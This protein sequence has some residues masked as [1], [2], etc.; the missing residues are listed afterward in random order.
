MPSQVVSFFGLLMM[1]AIAWLMSYNRGSIRWRPVIWGVLL[2]F[3]IAAAIFHVPHVY[4]VFSYMGQGVAW[5]VEKVDVGAAFVFGE[6]Y[7]EHFFAFSVC[8]TIIF[9]SALTSLLYYLNIIPKVVVAFSWAMRKTMGISGAETLSASANVFVG[10]TEAPLFIKPYIGN[11][12]KSQL[13]CVMVGGFT[14]IA[15]GVMGAFIKMGI[16]PTHLMIACVIS[17]P[18]AIAL[19]KVIYPETE[20]VSDEASMK[21]PESGENPFDAIVNGTETGLQLALRVGAILIVFVTMLAIINGILKP[22]GEEVGTAA[23]GASYVWSLE[24]AFGKIFQPFAFMMGVEAGECEKVG[25]L[26]GLKMAA[27]EFIAYQQLSEMELSPRSTMIST[28]ALCGFANFAS[29]G[30]QIFGIGLLAPKQRP[31]LAKMSLWAMLTGTLACYMTACVAGVL[32][33]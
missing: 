19:A 26:L 18:A 16:D 14:T 15:M 27:N 9:F 12:T 7:Y 8:S 30:I 17:A 25:Q 5:V 3:G 23:G 13:F 10:Q 22:A 24:A 20:E 6:T 2:Q 4:S 21:I 28:F 32:H 1:I 33:S 11:M 29:M 31:Q